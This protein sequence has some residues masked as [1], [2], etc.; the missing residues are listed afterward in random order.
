MHEEM[1]CEIGCL[2]TFQVVNKRGSH[3]FEIVFGLSKI[4]I[5]VCTRLYYIKCSSE[6]QLIASYTGQNLSLSGTVLSLLQ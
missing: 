4:S 3:T 2:C 1:A 5:Y 6:R